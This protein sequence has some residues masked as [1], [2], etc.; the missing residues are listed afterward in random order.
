[1]SHA[2]LRNVLQ[3]KYPTNLKEEGVTQGIAEAED[4]VLLGVLR[5][6]LHNTVLHPDSVLGGAVV[7]YST[8]AIT[9]VEEER[10]S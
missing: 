9:F 3:R 7:V 10:A 4:K 8:P 5:H 6:S 1:V 2:N